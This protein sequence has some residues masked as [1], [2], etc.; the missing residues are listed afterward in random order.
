MFMTYQDQRRSAIVNEPQAGTRNGTDRY[1]AASHS[2]APIGGGNNLISFPGRQEA[3][4]IPDF[5]GR[6]LMACRAFREPEEHV[7]SIRR[8]LGEAIANESGTRR[9]VD[10]F[11]KLGYLV[12][13]RSLRQP[14]S[15]RN[16]KREIST[17]GIVTHNRPASVE[18]CLRSYVLN[19]QEY[20]RDVEFVI[21]DDSDHAHAIENMGVVERA[22]RGGARITYVGSSEKQAFAK[23]LEAAGIPRSLASFALWGDDAPPPYTGANRNCLLLATAGRL[24]V[25]LDDDVEC[26]ISEGDT[27]DCRL[28]VTSGYPVVLSFYTSRAAAIAAAPLAQQDFI[29]RHE[30]FLGADIAECMSHFD[31][32]ASPEDVAI[33]EHLMQSLEEGRGYVAFTQNGVYGDCGFGSPSGYL[34]ARGATRANL[35]KSEQSYRSARSSRAIQAAAERVTI[36]DRGFCMAY[37]LGLDNRNLLPPFSPSGRNQ[38]GLFGYVLRKCFPDRYGCHLPQAVL[39]DSIGDRCFQEDAIWSDGSKFLLTDIVTLAISATGW[40]A[41]PGHGDDPLASLGKC[42]AKFARLPKGEFWRLTNAAGRHAAAE[43]IEALERLL[44]AYGS[45]PVYWAE[46]VRRFC[47]ELQE[48]IVKPVFLV[49][50]ETP[51]SNSQRRA[52]DYTLRFGELLATWREIVDCT[53][54]LQFRG[55]ALGFDLRQSTGGRKQ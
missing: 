40:T 54:E 53:K 1:R 7:A 32:L 31:G 14:C 52:Q 36:C 48:A 8:S 27:P 13:D 25:T 26:R 28:A 21:V 29:A 35:L 9:I 20:E 24:L 38:D 51:D 19:A 16:R 15:T 43:R 47:N 41:M 39:H 30:R 45:E 11:I 18:R 34:S 5:I 22:T 50:Q 46:D 42:L 3:E 37:A 6:A 4:I 23:Y 2:L 49:P 12:S 10:D 44:Q 33:S 55:I 17:L